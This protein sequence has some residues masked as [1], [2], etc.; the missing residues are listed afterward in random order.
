MGSLY[1]KYTKQEV[2][3]KAIMI[4]FDTLSRRYLP[5]YGCE[6]TD[7]PNFERLGKKSATFDNFYV[8]SLPCMPARREL[9]TGRLNFL[10]RGWTPLEPFDDSMPSILKNS[11]TYTHLVTDHQHYWEDGGATYHNRYNS[12]DFVRGQEGDLWKGVVND[13]DNLP[14]EVKDLPFMLKQMKRQDVINRNYMEKEEDHYQARTFDKGMEFLKTNKEADNWFLQLEYFD[15]HEPFFVPDS[16]KEKY[17]DSFPEDFDW[18]MYAPSTGDSV[19]KIEHGRNMYAAL[20]AMCD[21]YLGK[22]LDFMDEENMWEDTMLIVNTDHGFLM[23]EK[24]WWGKSVMP[25]YN[26]IAHTPFFIWDPRSKVQGERRNALAQTI[27]I[28]PTLLEYF[29]QDIPKDM[30]GFSLRETVE[31]DRQIR[32]YAM[33]GY[34]GGHINVTDGDFVYMRS[35]SSFGNGPLYEYTLMPMDMRALKGVKTFKKAKLHNG[36]SFTK[37]AKVLKI[38]PGMNMF[39]PYL[40]GHKL[41]D[42]HKDPNQEKPINDTETELR[43]VEAMI[44]LMQENDAPKEQFKRVGL[45]RGI[46]EYHLKREKVKRIKTEEKLLSSLGV[47]FDGNSKDEFLS[48]AANVPSKLILPF[49]IGFKKFIKQNEITVLR[50]NHL[51]EF[52]KKQLPPEYAAFAAVFFRSS[53][54]RY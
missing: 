6:W 53:T 29:G 48:I 19:E 7:M 49:K 5:N 10:H 26:E 31:S 11:G 1:Q 38:K 32:E 45:G 42:L 24:E 36:F 17:K 13:P 51:I 46:S 30:Q 16:F 52:M 8:G 22:V 9:H 40:S 18:P 4:M 25:T 21:H 2:T 28:A 12:Y 34:H 3:M 33:Y 44:K 14:D 39:N 15:P 37:G 54:R 20:M 47:E 43:L 50:Q 27:D 23:G 41:F 35:C